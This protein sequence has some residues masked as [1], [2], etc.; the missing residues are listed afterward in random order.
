[1]TKHVLFIQGGGN[2][3]YEADAKLVGS[4][5]AALGNGYEVSYPQLQMDETVPDFGWC[6]QIGKEISNIKGDVIL[7]AH[8]LGASLVLKYLSE[9]KIR[10]KISGI[11]LIA[12][13]FWSG[14]ESW[15]KG[16]KLQNDFTEKLPQHIPIFLYHSMDDK[17]VSFDNLSVYAEKLPQAIVREIKKGGHQF[18]NDLQF[19]AKDIKTL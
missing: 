6:R 3:G 14:Q 1:V 4:L 10:K 16:L 13:P 5:K 18:S 7:V 19:V 8:S 11:F 12:T 9:T 17:E 15:M 2:G